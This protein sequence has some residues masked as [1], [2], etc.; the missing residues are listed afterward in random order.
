V[1]EPAIGF[2]WGTLLAFCAERS[3]EYVSLRFPLHLRSE[4][5]SR[6]QLRMARGI[7]I[8]HLFWAHGWARIW[9]QNAT[10]LQFSGK[11]GDVHSVLFLVV[12]VLIVVVV[13]IAVIVSAVVVV[14]DLPT[15]GSCKIWF[16]RR[17]IE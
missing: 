13:V 6:R 4:N 2:D 7:K 15:I 9:V 16:R 12:V 1:S 5:G 10:T 11:G 14:F 8:A 17:R 3:L